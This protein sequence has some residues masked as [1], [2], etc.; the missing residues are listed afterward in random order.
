MN[1]QQAPT[2]AMNLWGYGVHD[3]PNMKERQNVSPKLEKEMK[4]MMRRIAVEER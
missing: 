3:F 2:Q 1:D 4:T